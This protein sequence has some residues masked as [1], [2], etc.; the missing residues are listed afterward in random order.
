LTAL[1]IGALCK[2]AGFP[3]GVVNIVPGYGPIAG[4]ALSS[5]M[6]VN[7]IAFTGST[8][9][10]RKIQEAS[11]KSN[12]KRVSL[13]LGGK[14]PVI[15]LD[16]DDELLEKVVTS[17]ADAIFGN[18]GQ[19][20]CAPSRIFVHEAIYDKFLDKIKL[21]AEER[22]TGDPFDENTVHGSLISQVQMNRV[23]DYIK[24]GKEEGARC[25]TGG[26]RLPRK[27]YFIPP[28]VF[29]DVQDDMKIAKEEIFG[30]VL[31]VFKFSDVK[32]AL[33]RSNATTYGLGAGVFCKDINKVFPLVDALD[34]GSVWVNCYDIT[35]NQ[36]EQI[37]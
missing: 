12:L 24:S 10:G 34:A 1:A 20:C 16:V 19:S 25:I 18:Q 28:T 11:A 37:I 22:T 4:A 9:V 17:N 33:K 7:K 8:I 6:D 30:P 36:G 32:D 27:G 31:S 3:P 5:H 15:V 23:L 2:E 21:N 29:A 26:E 35:L 14:S 13:E